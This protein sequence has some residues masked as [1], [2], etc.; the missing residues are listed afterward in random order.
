MPVKCK[1]IL[2][3]PKPITHIITKW[4]AADYT[5]SVGWGHVSAGLCLSRKCVQAKAF[6]DSGQIKQHPKKKN[7]VLP[8]YTYKFMGL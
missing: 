6:I 4:R 5:Q 2:P 1:F 8:D 3:P 7:V